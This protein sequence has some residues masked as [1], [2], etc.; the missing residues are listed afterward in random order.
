MAP[1]MWLTASEAE[2]FAR[3]MPADQ[4]EGLAVA[5]TLEAWGWGSD[6]N[7]LLAGLLHDVGKS[8]APRGARYRVLVTLLESFAPRLLPALAAR[9]AAIQALHGHAARGAAMA[10]EA[11][12][13]IDVVGLIAGHHSYSVDARMQALQEADALH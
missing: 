2:L 13:S 9:S 3:M 6:R 8:L 1:P 10:A 11:G 5:S 7:L 4:F 12:L